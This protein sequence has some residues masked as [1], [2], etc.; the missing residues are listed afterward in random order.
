MFTLMPENW[1]ERVEIARAK[2]FP[3]EEPKPVEKVIIEPAFEAEVD[4]A[5]ENEIAGIVIDPETLDN[6]VAEP[7]KKTEAVKKTEE[8][9]QRPKKAG[10]PPKKKK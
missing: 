8:P 3:I 1:Q 2:Y 7:E 5:K 10:R 4:Q 9:K 6:T